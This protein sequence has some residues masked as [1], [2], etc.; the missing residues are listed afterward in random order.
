MRVLAHNLY[1]A[2]SLSSIKEKPQSPASPGAPG[3]E[4]ECVC[5][6]MCVSVCECV[7]VCVGVRWCVVFISQMLGE[8]I[9]GLSGLSQS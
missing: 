1:A 4:C 9:K 2:P 5:E 3:Y 6:C 7:R 8:Q